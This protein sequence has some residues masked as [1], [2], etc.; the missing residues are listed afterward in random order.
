MPPKDKCPITP[1]QSESSQRL[2]IKE[3]YG[4]GRT[5]NIQIQVIQSSM[6]A[7]SQFSYC[8]IL[9]VLQYTVCSKNEATG[10]FSP[11]TH[12]VCK[13]ICTRGRTPCFHTPSQES[14]I[15]LPTQEII[16]S[17]TSCYV[18]ICYIILHCVTLVYIYASFRENV[19]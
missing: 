2:E 18:T 8:I 11:C 17:F 13:P 10:N 4:T 19:L 1:W 15:H 5:Q 14:L 16:F 12:I 6:Q 7:T 9:L 3:N